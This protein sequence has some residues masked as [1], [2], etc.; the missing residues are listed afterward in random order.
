VVEL[1]VDTEATYTVLP[2]SLLERLGISPIKSARLADGRIVERPL[3]EARMEVEGRYASTTP[4][5]FGEEG[6]YLLGPMTGRA[7]L[8]PRPRGEKTQAMGPWG[9]SPLNPCHTSPGVLSQLSSSLC[10]T[11]PAPS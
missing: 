3:G 5:V 1:V 11:P 2:R 6:I 4:V 10:L 8:S 9:L 7:G